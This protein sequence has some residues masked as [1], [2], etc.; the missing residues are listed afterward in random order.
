MI[1]ATG[2]CPLR[3]SYPADHPL[4]DEFEAWMTN[5]LREYTSEGEYLAVH[6]P[7]RRGRRTMP[8]TLRSWRCWRR[9]GDWQGPSDVEG[10]AARRR[11]SFT[12]AW[13]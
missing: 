7:A 4:D 13:L 6:H 8:Q 5:L 11:G 2:D 3:F 12:S 10:L 9:T 1:W